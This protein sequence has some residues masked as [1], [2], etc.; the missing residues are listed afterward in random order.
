MEW[1]ID[2]AVNQNALNRFFDGMNRENYEVHTLQIYKGG[3]QILRLAQ[4]PYSC[5]DAREV[6]SLSKMFASTVVGIAVDKGLVC[7]ED[8]LVDIFGREDASEKFSHMK[9]RHL[10]SMNTGHD[11]CVMPDMCYAESSVEAFFGIEPV[12]EPGTHFT[13]NTGASCM[14]CSVVE[15]VT[16]T[17]FFDFACE[18]LFYPL[19]ITNVSWN[20]CLDGVCCGGVG[21]HVSNDDIMKLGLMYS[22]GGVYQGRRILSESWIREASS[23]VSDNSANGSPDWCSGYGYQIWLN[24]RDG[25]RGDGAFGQLCMILPK[26]D[27]VVAVQAIGN[28][29]QS[30]IDHLFELLDDLIGESDAGTVYSFAS[31]AGDRELPTVDAVYRLEKN[32]ADFRTVWIRS[33][34]NEVQAAFSD[35]GE[36]Q[37]VTAKAGCW[38]MNRC[39]AKNMTPTLYGLEPTA[40]REQ[41]TVAASCAQ[42]GE[43]TVICQR[44]RNNPH[45]E[46]MEITFRDDQIRIEFTDPSGR[47]LRPDNMRVLVG[48]KQS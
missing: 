12:Y 2:P 16:G 4:E 20:R 45:T 10:L 9:L 28:D 33:G 47:V 19:G 29:M 23:Y 46:H 5:T 15:K 27:M 40:H 37:T 39:A 42:L 32:P 48:R 18:N 25:Y 14:L 34:G 1:L 3:R 41:I 7:V 38:T 6:Y 21:L 17:D 35:G 30:E 22:N 43:K 26:H 36:I 24:S 44:Y 31:L 8:K 13:Y 11:R